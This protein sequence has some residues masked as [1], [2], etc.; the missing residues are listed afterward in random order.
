MACCDIAATGVYSVEGQDALANELAGIDPNA[1][2]DDWGTPDGG[3]T[4]D[5]GEAWNAESP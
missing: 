5:T 1:P 2:P 3:V 4:A